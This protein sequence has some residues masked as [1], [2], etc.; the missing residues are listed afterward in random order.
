MLDAPGS[1]IY[2]V[3]MMPALTP[4]LAIT[5]I[6]GLGS[7]TGA[8]IALGSLGHAAGKALPSVRFDPAVVA[9]VLAYQGEWVRVPGGW[10]DY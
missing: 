3:V 5:P 8:L 2:G 4:Q 10:R 1:Q 7:V 6:S 9:S